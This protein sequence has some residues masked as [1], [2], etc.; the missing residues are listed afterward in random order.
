MLPRSVADSLKAG[1]DVPPNVYTSAS[2]L[3]THIENF[4]TLCDKSTPLQIVAMLNTLF[5]QFDAI[6]TAH[7]AYK[8]CF[9]LKFNAA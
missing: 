4:T 3:F 5:S 2:V 6:I 8:A 7:D 9:T 1:R